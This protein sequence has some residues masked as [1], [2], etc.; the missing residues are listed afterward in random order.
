MS[1]KNE[2]NLQKHGKFKQKSMGLIF[3]LKTVLYILINLFF[4]LLKITK[5]LLHS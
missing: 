1:G 5:K 3:F 2:E 4:T